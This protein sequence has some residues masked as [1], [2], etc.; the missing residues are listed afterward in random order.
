MC[1]GK[2]GVDEKSLP[3]SQFCCKL[4]S[5]LKNKVLKNVL[6]LMSY[7]YDSIKKSRNNKIPR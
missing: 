1:D 4:K 2:D 5:A 6:L 3:P 7:Y